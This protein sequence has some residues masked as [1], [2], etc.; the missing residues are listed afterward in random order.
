MIASKY[1]IKDVGQ[2]PIEYNAVTLSSDEVTI[3][4][5]DNSDWKTDCT[6]NPKVSSL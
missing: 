4:I 5:T 3:K 6:K 2:G 1:M